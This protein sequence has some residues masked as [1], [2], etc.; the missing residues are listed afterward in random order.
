MYRKRNNKYSLHFLFMDPFAFDDFC[1]Q[2]DP[3]DDPYGCFP[4]SQFSQVNEEESIHE[5]K[6]KKEIIKKTQIFQPFRNLME[7]EIVTKELNKN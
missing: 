5:E 2:C 7:L 3:F 6:P 4:F 1:Y